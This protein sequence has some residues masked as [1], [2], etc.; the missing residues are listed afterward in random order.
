MLCFEQK[1]FRNVVGNVDMRSVKR[2][3]LFASGHIH[4][5]CLPLPYALCLMLD[6]WCFMPFLLLVLLLLFY[7]LKIIFLKGENVVN[8]VL[9]MHHWCRKTP[10]SRTPNCFTSHIC[11]DKEIENERNNRV[12]NLREY[13]HTHCKCLLNVHIRY[14]FWLNCSLT[15]LS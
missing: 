14:N 7:A 8:S 11:Q 4:V 9:T 13:I 15:K 1:Y 10:F 2:N 5:L 3:C 6:V 12:R